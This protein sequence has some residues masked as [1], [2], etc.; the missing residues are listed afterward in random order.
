MT[1]DPIDPETIENDDVPEIDVETPKH[2]AVEQQADITPEEDEL[3]LG[4]PTQASEAD[5]IEQARIVSLDEDD[6]R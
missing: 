5:L 1:F 4:D 3:P 2:D 6:Y